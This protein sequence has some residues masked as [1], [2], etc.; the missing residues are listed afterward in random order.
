MKRYLVLIVLIICPL[1]SFSQSHRVDTTLN[2]GLRGFES[3]G[4]WGFVD[5]KGKI[6]IKPRFEAVICF[7]EGLCPVK[8]NGKWG[9]INKK[10]Q[11]VITPRYGFA[12]GFRNGYSIVVNNGM[13]GAI[14]KKGEVTVPI[15][16]RYRI[17]DFYNDTAMT[18]IDTSFY[19]I[20]PRGEIIGEIKFPLV[21][22]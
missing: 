19:Y 4:K 10:G 8:L 13:F 1:F 14:N 17:S 20:N 3:N 15:K 18:Q 12:R 9:F 7:Q 16:F 11:I 2:E 6:I 21:E 22:R 5:E